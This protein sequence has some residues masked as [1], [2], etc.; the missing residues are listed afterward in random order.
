MHPSMNGCIGLACQRESERT[1]SAFAL[2]DAMDW[3]RWQESESE[4]KRALCIQ[5]EDRIRVV[6][7]Y[8]DRLIAKRDKDAA[9]IPLRPHEERSW[10]KRIG[11]VEESIKKLRAE[12]SVNQ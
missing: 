8:R 7:R 9:N 12:L 11:E 5:I 2:S 3:I 4:R 6:T 10:A 1:M